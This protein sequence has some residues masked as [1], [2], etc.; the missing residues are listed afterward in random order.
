MYA[1]TTI[2]IDFVYQITFFVALTVLDEERIQNRR[3]DVLIC[4]K[5]NDGEEDEHAADPG[6]AAREARRRAVH[7]P[8]LYQVHGREGG[9]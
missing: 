5:V 7:G 1:F 6:V 8:R 9:T 4:Y 2:G 3:K